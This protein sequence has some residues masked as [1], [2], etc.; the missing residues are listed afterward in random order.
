MEGAI[1]ALIDSGKTTNRRSW[2]RG[3]ATTASAG[4]LF[5]FGSTTAAGS[6]ADRLDRYFEEF[7]TVIDIVEAGADNTGTESVVDVI[8][9]HRGDDTLLVFPPGEY[10]MDEQVRFTGFEKFGLAGNDATLV[11]ADYQTFDGPQYRL[12]RLGVEYSPGT[13]LVFDGFDIDQT[14]PDTG[15]RVIDAVVT[16]GLEVRDISV[17]GQHDSGTWGPG[18]FTITDASG[19]GLVENFEAPDGGA[20]VDETPNDG[21]LWRGPT[22]LLAN[23]NNGTLRFVD[24]VLGGFPDNGLYA[25]GGS[26]K[27]V[28]DGGVFKNS[29]AACVRVGGQGSVVRNATIEVDQNRPQDSSHRGL[30]LE[31]GN[32]LRAE[33]VTIRNYEPLPNSHGVSVMNSCES[34]WMEDVNVKISGDEVD[35]GVVIS[36]ECGDVVLLD[37][38]IELDTPGGF[39]VRIHGEEGAG[40]VILEHVNVVGEAGDESGAAGIRCDR[41]NVRFGKVAVDQPGGT[42]RRAV[43]N[44]G[45]NLKIYDGFYRATEHPIIDLGTGTW[46]EE[47]YAKSHGDAEAICLYDESADVYLK[48][49]KLRGGIE[50]YGS[51]GL[52]T[53]GNEY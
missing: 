12:F 23:S 24:C 50:D 2:L 52:K 30:R 28:V 41:D 48:N 16:D 4:A 31:N 7:G 19:T 18:R 10:Y 14:A 11:P 26:G 35:H 9:E 29:N 33:N 13:R 37:S 8:R 34:V 53:V 21:N 6:T 22:G 39:G 17:R 36:P 38:G 25:S 43:V 5:G 51:E 32:D 49:N 45:D 3:L 40:D 47:V 15:I 46:V 44:T 27:I 20:W 1:G 42:N